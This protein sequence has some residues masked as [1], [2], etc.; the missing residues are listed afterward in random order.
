MRGREEESLNMWAA[1]C[2]REREN[3]GDKGIQ[4]R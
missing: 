3:R 1:G 2:E 4:I